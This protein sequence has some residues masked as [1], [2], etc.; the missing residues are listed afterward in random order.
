LLTTIRC[1]GEVRGLLPHLFQFTDAHREEGLELQNDLA[2]FEAELKAALEEIWARP[3]E[4]EG[5]PD[6]WATRMAEVEKSRAINPLDKVPKPDV[7][8]VKDWRVNLLDF[9]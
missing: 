8:Q 9:L 2:T 7:S 1:Q 5:E 3:A 6:G 4:N